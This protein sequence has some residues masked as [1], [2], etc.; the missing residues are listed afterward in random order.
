ME[1]PPWHVIL[2]GRGSLRS[3][4][5]EGVIWPSKTCAV[6]SG[7]LRDRAGEAE[8]RSF[9]SSQPMLPDVVGSSRTEWVTE[10]LP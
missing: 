7:R 8:Y 6:R 9:R 3:G 1:A 2:Q 10:T 5:P 4:L